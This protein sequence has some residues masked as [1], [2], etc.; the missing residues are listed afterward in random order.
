MRIV[1]D[2]NVLIAAFISRGICSELLERCA[3]GHTLL[4]STFILQEFRSALI[5]KFGFSRKEADQAVSLLKSRMVM[6]DPP[7]LKQ[8]A[9]RDRDDDMILSTALSANARC[10]VSGDEDLLVLKKFHGVDIISPTKF[11]AYEAGRLPGPA[12]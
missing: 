7:P 10:V 12:E 8:S 3:R 9:C 4:S 11:W 1:L 6:V 2:T 5:D